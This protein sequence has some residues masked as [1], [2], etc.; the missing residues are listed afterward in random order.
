MCKYLMLS[1]TPDISIINY[2]GI[3]VIKDIRPAAHVGHDIRP[4]A[5]ISSWPNVAQISRS[6]DL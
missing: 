5:Y 6:F 2:M 1:Y 3:V 4:A